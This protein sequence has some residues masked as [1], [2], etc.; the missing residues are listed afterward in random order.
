MLE[1]SGRKIIVPTPSCIDRCAEVGWDA[2]CQ[3]QSPWP[4]PCVCMNDFVLPSYPGD[5]D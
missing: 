4:R 3:M 1:T 2:A 5:K